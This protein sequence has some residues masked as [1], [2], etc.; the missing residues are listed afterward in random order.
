MNV[1]PA[2][3]VFPMLPDDELRALADDITAHGLRHPI[4]LTPGGDL[5]DGRN[6]AAA[7]ELAGIEPAYVTH[8]GDPIAY[9]LSANV[10][11]RHMT[12]GARAMATA[13]VLAGAGKRRGGRWKRGALATTESGTTAWAQRMTEAGLVLDVCPE[14]APAVISGAVTLHAAHADAVAARQAAESYEARF[15]RLPDELAAQVRDEALT[16]DDALAVAA[17]REQR[18][19]EERRDARALL[20]RILD[21]AAPVQPSLDFADAWA[22]RLGPVEPDLIT[23]IEDA[24]AVLTDLRKRVTS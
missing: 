3:A 22:A 13:V 23:R 12:T 24:I 14:L 10:S 6:R 16:L 20:T 2:A 17:R 4:V 1:H 18:A 8:D 7:C 9:V 15:A 19:A 5:L 21:L 11:R